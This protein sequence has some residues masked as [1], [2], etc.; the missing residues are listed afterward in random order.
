MA[1]LVLGATLLGGCAFAPGMTFRGGCAADGNG[2]PS[3]ACQRAA[4]AAR[5]SGTAGGGPRGIAQGAGDAPPTGSLVEI[6]GQLI[7]KVRAA[8]D[9]SIPAD[10]SALFGKPRPYTLGP[11][12]V[13]AIV[14]WDHPELNMPVTQGASTGVDNTGSNAIVSGYTVD[15][16]GRVQFAYIGAVEVAGLTELEARERVTARLAKFIRDPQVTLRIQAYRSR[17]IYL[18]GEVRLPGLQVMNDLPMTLPEAINRAGGL[19]SAGDRARISV[20]RGDAT[21]I[22]NLPRLVAQGIN[23][24]R[25]LLQDGD[26]VRVY[27]LSDTKV[28]VLGEVGH[29]TTLNFNNGRLSLGEALG[30]AGGVSQYSADASQ[31]YVIRSQTGASPTIFH[32][33]ATSPVSMALAN[34]FPLRPDDVV[35]VDASSLVRWSRVVGMFLPSAQTLATGRS[36]AY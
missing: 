13:L 25:I 36:I 5:A 2:A 6:D 4:S 24:D 35:F 26:L 27:P 1:A 9:P 31:V 19:T 14:V 18:D 29:T 34:E 3:P 15:T 7:T 8:I 12:D 33:D 10:V 16:T 22:V 28:F 17:R 11:G 30:Y 23:P 20:T 21:A 32:L